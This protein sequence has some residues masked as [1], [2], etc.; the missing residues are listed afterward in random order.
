MVSEQAALVTR[1]TTVTAPEMRAE[2]G[3]HFHCDTMGP[4]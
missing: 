4:L 2:Q 3:H 1:M